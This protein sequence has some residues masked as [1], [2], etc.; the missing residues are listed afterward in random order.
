[1]RKHQLA[2]AS[3]LVS[4]VSLAQGSGLEGS[5]QSQWQSRYVTEG[6][7]NLDSNPLV[8][9]GVDLTH[10][11]VTAGVWQAWANGSDYRENNLFVEYAPYVEHWSPYLNVTYLQFHPQGADDVETGAGFTAPIQPW[12][13]VSLDGT[14]SKQASGAFY[15]LTLHTQRELIP[16]LTGKLHITQTYDDGY[17]SDDYNART[18]GKRAHSY[19]GTYCLH[20]NCM[21]AGSTAGPE[22]TYA[23]TAV[24]TSAGARSA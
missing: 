22:K 14:W 21:R 3:I 24:M 18:T 2:T 19:S 23:G 11:A 1:M 5:F 17:A 8:S 4:L 15:A 6:R 10:Q 9:A 12:L 20:W 16:N 7:D 13:S